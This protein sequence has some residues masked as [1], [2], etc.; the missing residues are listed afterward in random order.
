M[1]SNIFFALLFLLS[2]V[3]QAALVASVPAPWHLFPLVLV[4]GV[5]LLHERSLA[6]GLLWIA[7]SGLVLEARGLGDGLAAASLVATVAAAGLATVLFAKRSFWALLGVGA[8][9]LAAFLLAR[10]GWVAGLSL[11]TGGR[12]ALGPLVG[13]SVTTFWLGIV[14]IF[15]F[16]AY[17]RR[18]IRWSRD[19]FVRPGKTYDISF[20]N[21]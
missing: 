4:L 9:T 12:L 3:L 18:F 21:T 16:G 1:I 7:A 5:I 17:L 20:P 13:Q 11:F 6:L 10:I 8:G 14:G 15:V 2:V 19:K